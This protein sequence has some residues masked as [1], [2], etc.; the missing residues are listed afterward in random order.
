M[1]RS[2][3]CVSRTR[4]ENN[5]ELVT[6]YGKNIAEIIRSPCKNL[7]AVSNNAG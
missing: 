2:I 5:V 7:V 6:F 3:A 4:S 1:R